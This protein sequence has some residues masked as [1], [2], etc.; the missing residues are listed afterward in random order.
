MKLSED[1]KTWIISGV[2]AIMIVFT[3]TAGLAMIVPTSEEILP[4]AKTI[5]GE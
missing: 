2:A 1:I 5:L 3:L 4:A